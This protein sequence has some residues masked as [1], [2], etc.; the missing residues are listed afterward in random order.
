MKDMSVNES[1]FWIKRRETQTFRT[2]CGY[3]F[4]QVCLSHV[5]Q[6]IRAIGVSGVITNIESW[7]STESDPG[8]QIDLLLNPPALKCRG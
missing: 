4:L 7:R 3:A 5:N 1:N 8:V 2:W 6:I